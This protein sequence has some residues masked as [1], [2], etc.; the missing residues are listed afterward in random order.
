MRPDGNN[1]PLRVGNHELVIVPGAVPQQIPFR[2]TERISNYVE[3][4]MHPDR[5]FDRD[6]E[7]TL[8]YARCKLPKGVDPA[9]FTIVEINPGTGTIKRT[10]TS[11]VDTEAKTVTTDQLDHSSG[12]AIGVG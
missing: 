9:R 11:K 12:Y 7:L 1:R 8:S 6:C 10:L 5:R 4:E 2:L 3:V